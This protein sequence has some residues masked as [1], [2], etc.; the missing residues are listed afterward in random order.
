MTLTV[1]PYATKDFARCVEILLG[2]EQDP[3]LHL[4]DFA[5]RE[6]FAYEGEAE[7]AIKEAF[8]KSQKSF[9]PSDPPEKRSLTLGD[10]VKITQKG[11]EDIWYMFTV[12]DFE[13]ISEPETMIDCG[14]CEG[15]GE[16]IGGLGGDGEDEECPV[17][18]GTR[19]IIDPEL[20]MQ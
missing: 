10:L 14:Q 1:T 13:E 18:D 5:Q 20:L 8:V 16:I 2:I 12:D 6:A 7:D 19:K 15:T 9:D 4:R 3:T 17:C 11:Q